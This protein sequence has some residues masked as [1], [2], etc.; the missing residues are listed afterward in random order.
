LLRHLVR[1]NTI[2]ETTLGN[3]IQMVE[4]TRYDLHGL[5]TWLLK[6]LSDRPDIVERVR[7]NPPAGASGLTFVDAIPREALRME[8]SELLHRIATDNIVFDGY[9]I[10]KGSR[11]RICVWEAHHDHEKFPEPFRFD[12]DRFL[13]SKVPPEDYS[14]F[15]LDKH[16][17]LG[18]DWTYDLSAIFVEELVNGYRWQVVAD[19]PPVPGKFHFE[20]S[21]EFSLTLQRAE[22]H[23]AVASV[24]V[25]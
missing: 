15:G 16:R 8:Q 23:A 17:C 14:P 2:V 25:H 12:C 9:F 5:W 24:A 20:P 6:M 19:G 1:S 22:K 10:P 3:L 4:A 21:H 7:L 18:A 13:N 11:V